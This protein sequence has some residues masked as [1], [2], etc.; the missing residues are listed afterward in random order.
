MPVRLAFNLSPPALLSTRPQADRAGRIFRE[1]EAGEASVKPLGLDAMM[2]LQ[3][4]RESFLEGLASNAAL[5]A[6]PDARTAHLSDGARK[7]VGDYSTPDCLLITC[8]TFRAHQWKCWE[9]ALTIMRC[10]R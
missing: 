7:R 8:P 2:P 1:A 4:A 10:C 5:S 9:T 6:A 3:A